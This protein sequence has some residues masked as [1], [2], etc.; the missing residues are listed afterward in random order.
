MSKKKF[1]KLYKRQWLNKGKGSA[2]V[3]TE[4]SVEQGW[5]DKYPDDRYVDASLELKDCNRQ[6]SLEFGYDC[7]KE[8]KERLAKIDVVINSANELKQF[9][10][11]NPPIH[12]PRKNARKGKFRY[13]D[14][15]EFNSAVED[16]EEAEELLLDEV[17]EEGALTVTTEA[18]NDRPT[19][20]RI[21]DAGAVMVPVRND[22]EAK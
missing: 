19:K 20:G 2:Y 9:M 11:D 21:L 12:T 8:Y 22:D 4:A 14:L 17:Y 16:A 1:P 15:E 3:M 6:M 5:N 18:I 13:L 7:D 10:L